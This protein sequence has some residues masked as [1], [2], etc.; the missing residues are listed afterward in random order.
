MTE[1]VTMYRYPLWTLMTAYSSLE[2]D[3]V[4]S[5]CLHKIFPFN[6]QFDLVNKA[7]LASWKITYSLFSS[8]FIAQLVLGYLSSSLLLNSFERVGGH[9]S[10]ATNVQARGQRLYYC[11]K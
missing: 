9:F 4:K 5:Y 1:K 11:V 3:C 6:W 8:L 2:W 7:A 10:M